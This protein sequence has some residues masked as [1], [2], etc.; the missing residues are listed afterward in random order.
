MCACPA[1]HRIGR[2][3]C[4]F[5]CPHI[6]FSLSWT[7]D[8]KQW[9]NPLY[10]H[11]NPI[12]AHRLYIPTAASIF[13]FPSTLMSA[14]MLDANWYSPLDNCPV[15]RITAVIRTCV[16]ILPREKDS[17]RNRSI[18]DDHANTWRRVYVK[19]I[20]GRWGFARRRSTLSNKQI[21]I[22]P[23]ALERLSNAERVRRM[24]R[25]YR[26]EWNKILF[27]YNLQ[28]VEEVGDGPYENIKR[29]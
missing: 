27:E 17:E 26:L 20:A 1:F 8:R 23:L 15:D 13:L 14:V 16:L 4:T 10:T 3:P 29:E 21:P 24:S 12:E 7:L 28:R 2:F 19:S 5:S 11:E 18:D 25:G 6:T 22:V 9:W